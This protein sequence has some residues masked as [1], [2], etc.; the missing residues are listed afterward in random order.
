MPEIEDSKEEKK[1]VCGSLLSEFYNVLVFIKLCV[2]LLILLRLTHS[3]P[4]QLHD[5]LK[6]IK[7]G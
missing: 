6:A 4:E 3:V 5:E 2:K 1:Q 7:N